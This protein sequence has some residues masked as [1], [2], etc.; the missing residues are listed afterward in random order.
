[1]EV[2]PP[3]AL[4]RWWSVWQRNSP[5]IC[6]S[7]TASWEMPLGSL[8][9]CMQQEQTMSQAFEMLALQVCRTHQV[10]FAICIARETFRL[11]WK[12][13]AFHNLWQTEFVRISLP[14]EVVCCG[15][16]LKRNLMS[17]LKNC[18]KS[19]NP[20]VLGEERST[21]V[22]VLL[23]QEQAGWHEREDGKVRHAGPGTWERTLPSECARVYEQDD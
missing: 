8:N 2:I 20:W 5:H 12:N 23:L 9:I 15:R 19:G 10:Y 16:I 6:H 7:Y 17:G 22:C 14:R 21:T 3:L 13:L 11:S 1:M 18:L 4:D